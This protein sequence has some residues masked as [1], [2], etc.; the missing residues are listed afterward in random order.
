MK[1]T[2]DKNALSKALSTV[3]R[4]VESRTTIP[5]LTNV[6]LSAEGGKLSIKAT[7][8]DLEVTMSIDADIELPGGTTVNGKLFA[9]IA[10][11]MA[12]ETITFEAKDGSALVK[13]GRSKFSLQTLPL[14]DYPDLTVG[15]FTHEFEMKSADLRRMFK[16]TSF[17]VSTEETRYYLNGIF[18]HTIAVDGQTKLR[19][20]A[21]D[22]HRL[23]RIEMD[24][25]DGAGGM[26]GIIIPRKTV[27]EVDKILDLSDTVQVFISENKHQFR[28]GSAVM[29]SKAIDGNFPPYDRVIPA[30]SNNKVFAS[31]VD[32]A[33][34]VDRVSTVS[35]Q[36]GRAVKISFSNG[37]AKLHVQNPEMGDATEEVTVDYDAEP[38]EIGF[39]AAY[40][41]DIMSN[42]ETDQ[43]EIYLTDAGS[44]ALFHPVGETDC[45][46]V[47]MPMRV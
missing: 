3:S 10:R 16:R 21:T 41:G 43:V 15:A 38:I 36:R 18:F 40:L 39:N 45:L 1:F 20:V 29:T 4:V 23:S 25:P 26:P 46:F 33:K 44:P 19:A 32:F 27:G 37:L 13:S 24:A 42:V 9:D 31:K 17:A 30:I 5:I 14:S 7:D 35:S 12:G 28:V 2:I 8:L 22:G 11:K 6:A 47:C 34:A